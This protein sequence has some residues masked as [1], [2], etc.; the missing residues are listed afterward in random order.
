M[1]YVRLSAA[2]A[3]ACAV[4]PAIAASLESGVGNPALGVAGKVSLRLPLGE[5]AGPKSNLR[6]GLAVSRQDRDISGRP[7]GSRRDAEAVGLR[8]GLN[9]ERSLL[10]GGAPITSQD[11]SNARDDG[12]RHSAWRTVAFVAGGVVLV[13]GAGFAYLLHEAERNSD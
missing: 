3:I 9:G 5:G 4:Q 6:L 11:R 12:E 1:L 10:M 7:V 2:I 13:A 8:R